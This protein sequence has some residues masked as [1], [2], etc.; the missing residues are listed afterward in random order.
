VLKLLRLFLRLKLAD[1]RRRVRQL[2]FS[3]A[4]LEA[5]LLL[6]RGRS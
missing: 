4:H 5:D 6:R 3:I 1:A 2:E